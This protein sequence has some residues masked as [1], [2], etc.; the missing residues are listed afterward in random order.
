[1]V[2]VSAVIVLIIGMI[3]LKA[4]KSSASEMKPVSS[5]DIVTLKGDTLTFNEQ[6]FP[7]KLVVNFYSSACDLCMIELGDILY[8]SKKHD[9]ELLFITAD[10]LSEMETFAEHLKKNG[11]SDAE[12]I[13]LARIN[14]ED[15]NKL[16]GN[17]SVPQTIVFDT[18]LKP[19]QIKKGL[20]TSGLLQKS[21]E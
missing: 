18:G 5:F 8:F 1:M 10:S 9:V 4:Q 3:V 13:T 20:I 6:T 11:V 14:L 12:K 7:R 21:F 15:A 19:K 16:F 2:F 17:I